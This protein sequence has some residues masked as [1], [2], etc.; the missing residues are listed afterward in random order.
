MPLTLYELMDGIGLSQSCNVEHFIE[1]IHPPAGMH[2]KDGILLY[3]GKDFEITPERRRYSIM[4]LAPTILHYFNAPIPEQVDGKIMF[5]IF[6][7]DSPMQKSMPKF[8]P[9]IYR[10]TG[11]P[12]FAEADD[13]VRKRLEGLGY[14]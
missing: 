9:L 13:E 4:D 2:H 1:D 6:A 11:L 10:E 14:I 12:Q 8:E 3:G 7:K 5:D